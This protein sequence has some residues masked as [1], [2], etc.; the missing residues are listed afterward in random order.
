MPSA[1]SGTACTLV[2][3]VA[4]DEAHEADKADPGEVEKIKAEQQQLGKGK[5]GQQPVKAFKP[6]QA[7]G[8]GDNESD[9]DSDQKKTHWVEIELKTDAG[10]PVAGEPY[11]ITLPD[12]TVASG[13]LDEKGLARIEGLPDA[14]SCQVTFP[15]RDKTVWKPA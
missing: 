9:N 11:Q 5:Y 13:T 3:P 2:A 14:G 10:D 12:G 1:K 6:G 8:A 4:P 7:G 15:K